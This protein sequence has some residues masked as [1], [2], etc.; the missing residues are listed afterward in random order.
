MI[1]LSNLLHSIDNKKS[2]LPNHIYHYHG[3]NLIIYVP[4]TIR[5][6]DKFIRN[7]EKQYQ[8][9]TVI[10]NLNIFKLE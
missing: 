4:S 2:H 7:L 3:E 9:N 6:I 8:V 1:P 10:T 5:Y